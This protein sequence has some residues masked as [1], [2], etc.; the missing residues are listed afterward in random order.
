MFEKE[1][2]GVELS[3]ELNQFISEW[4]E[5]PGN[6]IMILHRVQEEY[7]YIPREVALELSRMLDVPLAKIYGVITFYHFFKL[8]KP[9]KNIIQV[10][11][12]TACYLKGGGDLISELERLLGL[13]VNGTTDDGEFSLEAVRCIG[14]C[15]LAPVMTVNGEVFG[16]IT[17]EQLPGVIS[18]FKGN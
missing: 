9:G 2:A 4:K 16:K 18:K 13:P 8:T 11:M 15:G 6:L 7:G 1:V 10:C 12:G 17:T 3:A 14:C 5:K